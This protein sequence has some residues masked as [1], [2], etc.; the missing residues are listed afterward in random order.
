LIVDDE[1]GV[2]RERHADSIGKIQRR[3][4]GPFQVRIHADR[5]RESIGTTDS[6]VT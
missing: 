1:V 6:P 5:A 2:S 3:G 4:A